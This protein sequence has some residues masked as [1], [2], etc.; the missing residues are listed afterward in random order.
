MWYLLYPAL[1]LPRF[2]LVD[3]KRLWAEEELF[4]CAT[5]RAALSKAGRCRYLAFSDN[6]PPSFLAS[7]FL[8]LPLSAECG[9][10]QQRSSWP[11]ERRFKFAATGSDSSG[12]RRRPALKTE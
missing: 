12:G 8:I 6:P 9:C 1:A 3:W 5:H 2:H 10:Q 7:C 4:R 11:E